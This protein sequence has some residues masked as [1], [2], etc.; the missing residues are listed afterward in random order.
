[1]NIRCR[2]TLTMDDRAELA[3][4]VKGGKGRGAAAQAGADPFGGGRGLDG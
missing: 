4:M 2:V 1:M 3:E